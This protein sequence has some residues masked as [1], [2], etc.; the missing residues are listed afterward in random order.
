MPP[1]DGTEQEKDSSQM[2]EQHITRRRGGFPIVLLF[3]AAL[4]ISA[5]GLAMDNEGRLERAT[6]ALND[7]D[8][9]AAI[10][11]TRNI[12]QEEP[13]NRAARIVL[14]RAALAAG[15]PATAEKELKR[16]MELGQDPATIAVDL[17]QAMVSL[18]RYG[19]VLDQF[20]P[21]IAGSDEDRLA[22]LKLR[23]DAIM[24]QQLSTA[25]RNVYLEV[26][27][28]DPG[29]V[30]ARLGVAQS[31]MA[32]QDYDGARTAIDEALE[33]A[34][35]N[36]ETWLAS[37]MLRLK[38]GDAAGAE[39]DLAQGLELAQ[40]PGNARIAVMLLASLVDASLALN[41]IDTA[42]RRAQRLREL[43]PDFLV[44]RY[45]LARIAFLRDDFET[46]QV[47]LQQVLTAA[48]SYQPAGMLMGAVHLRRGNLSL[49]EMHLSS[50]VAAS[51]DNDDA[52]RLLVE[53]RLRQNRAE[54]AAAVLK[55]ILDAGG[56]DTAALRLAVR[57][58]LLAGDYDDAIGHLEEA[59]AE[60]PGDVD[61]TLDL[62]S[63]YL[64]ASNLSEA[65]RLI[66]AVPDDTGETGTRRA[67]LDV[68]TS[69]RRNDASTAL[70]RALAARDQWPDDP[71][72]HNLIGGIAVDLDRVDLAQQS[73]ERAMELAPEEPAGYVNLAR[74]SMQ[75][76][77]LDAARTHFEEALARAPEAGSLMIALARV[78]A[79]AENREAA[80]EWLE[81]ARLADQ[82]ALAPRLLLA[83]SYLVEEEYEKAR[84]AALEVVDQQR[85]HV[86]GLYLLG[87]AEQALGEIKSASA[88]FD[89][90]VE[91]D[92]ENIDLRLGAAQAQLR[93]GNEAIAEN[94][95]GYDV[96][97]ANLQVA[98]FQAGIRAR[99]GDVA[100]ALE[101]ARSLKEYHPDSAIPIALE[102][103]LLA[104]QKDFAAAAAAYDQA[105]KLA[106]DNQRMALRAHVIRRD[107]DLPAPQ[108]PL[109]E[110]LEERPLDS[111]AR[112]WLA[113]AYRTSDEP[114]KAK[115]HYQQALEA[116]PDNFVALNNLAWMYF[117]DEDPRAEELARRAFE[118]A[119][120]NASVADTLGWIQVNN[121]R[122]ED[123]IETLR[124]AVELN[125]DNAELRYHLAAALAQSGDKREA[126][127]LLEAVLA[128]GRDFGSRADAQAL[129]DSL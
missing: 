117:E 109:E 50:V 40:A 104:A 79:M 6:R 67:L 32:E 71:R 116:A 99:R 122:L 124:Q 57:A 10:I 29:N 48:P 115:M 54:A 42:D 39:D 25:A 22:I 30:E 52:R 110:Y 111:T 92:P 118:L 83:R 37:G 121:G 26:I 17:A 36:A 86:E 123:G 55:P 77:N 53:T 126:R 78:E 33:I 24:G 93:L 98:A 43:A 89:R 44:G 58:S 68:L 65:E 14:G 31:Y 41:D 46:A 96:N 59:L 90:A 13:D 21:E 108:L 34:P 81:Q 5:C 45:L 19:A 114:E 2:S 125:Q 127:Q 20:P 102:G 9:R 62:A 103:E 129:L 3:I 101:I 35:D 12:L 1:G 70:D 73:F 69:L 4:G 47:E 15:D 100:G 94:R 91:L 107:G 23:A 84:T 112:V 38:T 60:N 120:G 95:L 61:L 80:M 16:A 113:E 18:G 11:D 8:F 27:A 66:A 28:A 87:L 51:P 64:S 88:R 56:T 75:Q 63:A 105:R 97:P 7:G 74:L 85:D 72:V 76:G 49:A 106:P 119:P 82:A 128:G